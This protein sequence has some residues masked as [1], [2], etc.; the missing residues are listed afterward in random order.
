MDLND[1]HFAPL[2]AAHAV[3]IVRHRPHTYTIR[4]H[5]M[6]STGLKM[7]SQ[8]RTPHRSGQRRASLFMTAFNAIHAKWMLMNTKFVFSATV[9][10]AALRATGNSSSNKIIIEKYK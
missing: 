1:F 3:V 9:Q 5:G 2:S 4:M 8:L 7:L 10:T 6:V